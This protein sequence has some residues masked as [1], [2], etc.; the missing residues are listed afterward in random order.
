[1]WKNAVDVAVAGRAASLQTSQSL[2]K[3]VSLQASRCPWSHAW[4]PAPGDKFLMGRSLGREH[5]P[6][7]AAAGRTGVSLAARTRHSACNVTI[8]TL[9]THYIP[10]YSTSHCICS[11]AIHSKLE[12]VI[13]ISHFYPVQRSYWYFVHSLVSPVISK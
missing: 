10:L 2:T 5:Q 11:H 13:H 4:S 3:S 1:M 12:D 6:G 9:R 8:S 7:P